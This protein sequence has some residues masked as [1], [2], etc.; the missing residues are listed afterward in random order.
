MG[1]IRYTHTAEKSVLEGENDGAPFL[2][3]YHLKAP[4]ATEGYA[5]EVV[6]RIYLD[7]WRGI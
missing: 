7:N 3:C 1:L 2:F 4:L 5:Y 6:R